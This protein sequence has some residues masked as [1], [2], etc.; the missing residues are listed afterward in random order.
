MNV[1]KNIERKCN[2]LRISYLKCANEEKY[3]RA[4]FLKISFNLML[5]ALKL[6]KNIQSS[7]SNRYKAIK[8][9]YSD[10][11]ITIPFQSHTNQTDQSQPQLLHSGY[12]SVAVVS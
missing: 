5:C 9:K 10:G 12:S 2:S 6:W 1:F 4:L 3:L 8:N 7:K 11:G